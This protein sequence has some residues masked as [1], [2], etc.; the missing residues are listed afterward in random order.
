MNIKTIEGKVVAPEGMKVGIIASRFNSFIVQKLLDGA[1][2]GVGKQLNDAAAAGK[3][4]SSID[5]VSGATYSSEAIFDAY[6]AA[7]KKAAA[8]AGSTVKT[9]KPDKTDSSDTD[10]EQGGGQD[11]DQSTGQDANLDEHF[12]FAYCAS[13]AS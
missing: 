1:V 4:L 9:E 7:L 13:C 10:T 8:A 11:A 12:G 3:N 6:Y 5:T 2:D